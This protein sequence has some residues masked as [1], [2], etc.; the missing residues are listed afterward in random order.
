MAKITWKGS[1]LTAPI[2][3]ALV[4][5]VGADGKPNVLTVAWTGILCTHP[6]MTYIS[7]RPERYSYSLI[8]ES[9]V[10]AVNLTSAALIH[11]ADFCGMRTGRKVDKF[12]ACGLTPV[13]E[14]GFPC[15]LIEEAPLSLLCRVT[16]VIQ[17]GSHDMFIASIEKVVVDEALLDKDGKLRLDRAELAA[18][19]HG[20]YFALGRKL[21]AFGFSVAKKKRRVNDAGKKPTR[22]RASDAKTEEST[23]KKPKSQKK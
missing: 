7:V 3:P 13:Y 17:L 21:G 6:P 15:P 20:E 14:E 1:A 22:A 19:A 4:S 10:F 9:G 5:C 23:A 18:F 11:A 2:P 8:R 16:Q 12:A